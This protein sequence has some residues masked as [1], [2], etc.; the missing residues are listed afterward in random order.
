MVSKLQLFSIYSFLHILLDPHKKFHVKKELTKIIF[1]LFECKIMLYMLTHVFFTLVG[2]KANS[3]ND[4][5]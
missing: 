5:P 1:L 3:F 4:N 2:S